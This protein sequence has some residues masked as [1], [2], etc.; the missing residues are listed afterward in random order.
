MGN[1]KKAETHFAK[2]ARCG[3]EQSQYWAMYIKFLLEKQNFEKAEKIIRRADKYSVGTDLTFCKVAYNL[4]TNNRPA[5]LIDLE[6]ALQEDS[7]M[8]KILF[9]IIPTLQDDVEIKGMIRYFS[10]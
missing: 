1:S 2:A 7:S 6:E 5:A 4:L 9:E 10:T 3:Q 8:S